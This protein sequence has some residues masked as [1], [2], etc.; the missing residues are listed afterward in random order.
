MFSSVITKQQVFIEQQF[1]YNILQLFIIF[2]DFEILGEKSIL[3]NVFRV[4]SHEFVQYIP[5]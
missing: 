1:Q 2:G 5:Y 3:L 4:D